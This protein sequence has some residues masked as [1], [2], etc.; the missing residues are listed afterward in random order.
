MHPQMSIK[1]KKK[2]LILFTT[3]MKAGEEMLSDNCE[4]LLNI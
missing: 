1:L 3:K 4:Q 2:D